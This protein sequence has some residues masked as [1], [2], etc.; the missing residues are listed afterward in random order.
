M[1]KVFSLLI[2]TLAFQ[3]SFCQSDSPTL[4]TINNHKVSKAE[5]LRIYE[6]NSNIATEEK[7]SIDEYL[8]L[9]INYKLKVIEA[10][11]LGYDTA[12]SFITEMAGYRDQLA[13][14]YL[15]DTTV[16]DSLVKVYY[17]WSHYE[18]NVSHIMVKVGLTAP[19]ADTL[20][21]YK[22][23]MA[24]KDSLDSGIP[25]KK[26]AYDN[27]DDPGSKAHD[28]E[29]GWFSVFRM[30]YPFE[31]AAFNTPVGHITGPVRTI[32]GYHMLKV[33]G[34]RKKSEPMNVSHIMVILPPHASDAKVKAAKEKI[35]KAYDELQHGAKW[36]DV[37][38]KY[39]EHKASVNRGGNLGWVTDENTSENFFEHCAAMDSGKYS[40]PFRSR[41][42]YHIVKVIGYKPLPSFN[43]V[44]KEFAKKLS[45]IQQVLNLSQDKTLSRIKKEYGFSYH[46][47]NVKPVLALVDS[48]A[49]QG[50]WNPEKAKDMKAPVLQ[51]GNKTYTQYDLAKYIAK[52]R[53]EKINNTFTTN[54]DRNVKN[55]RINCIM[56]YGK[57][58][59]P[60]K[61][62]DYKNLLE[63][64]HD[65]IL[66]F[67]LTEDKVWKKAVQDSAGLQKF[68]D[69]MTNKYKWKERVK[70]SK[71][72]YSDSTLTAELLKLA[73]KR[74]KTGASGKDL[75]LKLCPKDTVPCLN[76]KEV[77]FEK[78]ENAIA[79]S[80]TWKKG[81]YWSTK[82]K[83]KNVL[84]YVDDLL[85]VQIK[86]LNE[87]RGLYTADYQT[88]LEKKWV[89]S[90]R[91]KYDIKVNQDV[92]QQI[93]KEQGEKVD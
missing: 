75:S 59:L 70:L 60:S 71:Y 53:F 2:A 91:K 85:P 30:I 29:L 17:N 8:Q 16:I 52:H 48:S 31:Q 18:L 80:I 78:G 5:F 33:N 68:Y 10:E 42:G 12:K 43:A 89:D 57:E 40:K 66:L 61:Y 62:P 82:N 79:D 47:G 24:I 93:K 64:Y 72:T 86:K 11:N 25:F 67:N 87:A 51:I 58:Q 77:T 88:Y 19:P 9:F 84:Y 73:K 83:G 49:Y 4:L 28:G 74:S 39:S 69:Q 1:R 6:K 65:G 15:T 56:S 14:P 27:S 63:E 50:K 32:Y 41:F 90:L 38:K 13:K 37:V 36:N 35:D 46:E 55:F 76:V 7:K 26:V 23:I 81:A 22:R 34:K 20:K 44:K 92:L 45:A 54:L 3:F 21:A